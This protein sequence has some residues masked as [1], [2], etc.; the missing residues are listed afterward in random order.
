MKSVYLAR[1]FAVAI[2]TLLLAIPCVAQKENKRAIKRLPSAVLSA[3]Q[4]E[5]P[6]AKIIGSGKERQ[7]GKTVY[8]VE[9]KDSTI[10]R[11]LIYAAN[12][13]VIEV[14]ESVPIKDLPEA[15]AGAVKTGYPKA[16][17][18]KSERLTRG[19]DVRYEMQLKEGKKAISLEISV[20][21]VILHSTISKAK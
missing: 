4:K 3:F 1:P 19:P 14:E 8:E 9:S 21:G 17:I 5:Y 11:D 13:N 16:Q 7:G 12:G 10:S 18:T 15:V 20:N 6:N 2:L